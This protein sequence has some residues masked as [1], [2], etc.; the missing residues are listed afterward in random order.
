[1]YKQIKHELI[2]FFFL[3]ILNMNYWKVKTQ[4]RPPCNIKWRK[5]TN[6]VLDWVEK[7]KKEIQH[8]GVNLHR[9]LLFLIPTR[10]K[11]RHS[12]DAFQRL[13]RSPTRIR[14]PAGHL[15]A[16]ESYIHDVA[17][18]LHHK[19]AEVDG[20]GVGLTAH[21]PWLRQQ[22]RRNQERCQHLTALKPGTRKNNIFS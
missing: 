7:G 14:S 16:G 22:W 10:R 17:N 18:T 21:P 6:L 13:Q 4:T 2:L 12:T 15:N 11:K 5:K 20:G 9:L 8:P 19:T 1:M 3:T